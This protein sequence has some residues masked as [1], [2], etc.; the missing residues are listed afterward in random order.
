MSSSLEL[1]NHKL[2]E[3]SQEDKRAWL[4]SLAALKVEASQL[5]EQ[6]YTVEMPTNRTV[7][8]TI[9]CMELQF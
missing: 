2:Y 9:K 6:G 7:S 3:Y 1:K 8:K 4:S 5:K